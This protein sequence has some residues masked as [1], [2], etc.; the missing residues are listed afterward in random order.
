MPGI[1]TFY[2]VDI[3]VGGIVKDRFGRIGTVVRKRGFGVL[4]VKLQDGTIHNE[5]VVDL[6]IVQRGEDCKRMSSHKV[7]RRSAYPCRRTAA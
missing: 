2:T 1:S 5:N 7:A 3:Q 6:K 4:H